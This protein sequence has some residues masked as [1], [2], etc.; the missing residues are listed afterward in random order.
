MRSTPR[1]NSYRRLLA[2][3]IAGQRL[4]N[5]SERDAGPNASANLRKIGIRRSLSSADLNEKGPPKRAKGLGAKR[6]WEID[7][8]TD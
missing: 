2:G 8:A 7:G 1:E 4:L 6:S 5:I 3:G